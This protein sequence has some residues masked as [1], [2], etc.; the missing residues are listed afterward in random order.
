MPPALE[1]AR[2]SAPLG[3]LPIHA[4]HTA[5][6]AEADRLGRQHLHA[7]AVYVRQARQIPAGALSGGRGLGNGPVLPFLSILS[8]SFPVAV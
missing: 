2:L 3:G 5:G 6:A 1:A 7:G 4:G 8:A